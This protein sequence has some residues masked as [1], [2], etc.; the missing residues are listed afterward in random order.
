MKIYI[1]SDHA[2]FNYKNEIIS[3]FSLYN[4]SII[5]CGCHNEN[6]IDYPDISTIVCNNI[7]N[8][9]K[10]KIDS[11]GILICGTGIGMSISANKHNGIRCA[12]IHDLFTAEMAKKHNNANIIALGSR[13]HTFEECINFINKFRDSEFE[14]GR[15]QDRINKIE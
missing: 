13:I 11:F 12:L 6:K 10:Y 5:D 15:H 7:K 9:L 8:D 3:K 1:G 2:G 4:N 14:K